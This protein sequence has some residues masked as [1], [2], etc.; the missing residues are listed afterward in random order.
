MTQ[1][2]PF[3]TIKIPISVHKSLTEY[4]DINRLKSI[5]IAV[6]DGI[7]CLNN[8]K[9]VGSKLK[10]DITPGKDVW[11]DLYSESAIYWVKYLNTLDNDELTNHLSEFGSKL[12]LQ[13]ESV[14]KNPAFDDIQN[15]YDLCIGLMNYIESTLD[16]IKQSECSSEIRGNVSELFL[17]SLIRSRF[18][19]PATTH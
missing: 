17:N 7:N 3:I 12:C 15:R 19:F 9:G 18:L 16:V 2:E 13:I 11:A 1:D 14:V 10:Y 6:Q 5:G 4:R 8:H